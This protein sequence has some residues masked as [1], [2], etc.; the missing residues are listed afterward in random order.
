LIGLW[1]NTHSSGADA[2]RNCQGGTISRHY[3]DKDIEVGTSYLAVITDGDR[4][5]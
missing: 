1:S 5:A 4:P 2:E 3:Q